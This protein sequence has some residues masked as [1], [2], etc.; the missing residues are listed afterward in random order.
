MTPR[1]WFQFGSRPI[2][3]QRPDGYRTSNPERADPKTLPEEFANNIL[4]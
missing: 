2:P 1:E 4:G 3:E